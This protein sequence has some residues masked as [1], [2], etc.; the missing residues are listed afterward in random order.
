MTGYRASEPGTVRLAARSRWDWAQHAGCA[1]E[2]LELFFGP[3]GERQPEREQRE[4]KAKEICQ[5]CPVR[6]ACADYAIAANQ[7]H[8]TWG[9][10][11]PEE[12]VTIRR[13]RMRRAQAGRAAA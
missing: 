6:P 2:S 12:R 10:Y 3:D 5:A 7:K 4:A 8:G 13:S 1:G 11:T 9:G